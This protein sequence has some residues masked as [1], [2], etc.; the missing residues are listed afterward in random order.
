MIFLTIVQVSLKPHIFPGVWGRTG[1][2][3]LCDTGT[4]LELTTENLDDTSV[5]LVKF[6]FGVILCYVFSPL[7]CFK[8]LDFCL[9]AEPSSSCVLF[10]LQGHWKKL[11]FW[12]LL[13]IWDHCRM[14]FIVCIVLSH[15]F[16]QFISQG[17]PGQ[18]FQRER[19][20]EVLKE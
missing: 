8:E 14:H 5:V 11:L 12:K 7:E 2:F 20:I 17:S 3:D 1:L 13:N 9:F 15:Y 10:A 19:E 18:V 6:I 16:T 4:L